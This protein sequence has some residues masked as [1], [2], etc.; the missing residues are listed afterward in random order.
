M[1]TRTKIL[2]IILLC[3]LALISSIAIGSV[4]ISSR[5]I[6]RI[7][8]NQFFQTPLSDQIQPTTVTIVWNI[9][10]P[11][12]FMAFMVGAALS[13]SGAVMQSMLRNPL[14]SSYTLGVSSGASLGAAIVIVFGLQLPFLGIFTL[15]FVGFL[16][17]FATVML[18]M[19]VTVRLDKNMT[20]HTIILVGMI[21]SLFMNALLTL[22]TAFS[23]QY[24]EQLVFWQM[25]SFAGRSWEEVQ[26]VTVIT[27]IG[28]LG[29]M[30]YSKE[31]D[32]MTFG[33]D[34]AVAMG[35]ELKKV[36]IYL[37]GICSLLTGAV[38]SFVGIIGFVDLIVPH[39]TRKMFSSSHQ[40]FLPLT[41]LI[42]GGFM[43][44][45][46]LV[47]RTIIAPSELPIGAVTALLG[48]PFFATLFFKNRKKG[49]LS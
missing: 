39:L 48:A 30:K 20:N 3:F 36:K 21:F 4:T 37:I 29:F 45:A 42:G 2:I 9:R 33:E 23:R 11:R 27:T 46:D 24:L 15:P 7:I 47:S 43:V 12:T 1:K 16:G 32:I 22:I 28:I 38:V 6:I 31:L 5:E 49:G 26:I 10:L 13:I 19:G 14:A 25:G 34:R 41:A 35:V 18:I 44:M 40:L 8:G 17:G